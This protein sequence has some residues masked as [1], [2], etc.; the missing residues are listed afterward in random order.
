MV[1]SKYFWTWA[2]SWYYISI[3]ACKLRP[4]FIMRGYLHWCSWACS[5]W[6]EL[7][8]QCMSKGRVQYYTYENV[9]YHFWRHVADHNILGL[10]HLLTSER[11]WLNID[12]FCEHYCHIT[13]TYTVECQFNIY[14]TVPYD[15]NS[16]TERR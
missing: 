12:G 14:Q 5:V 6:Y 15:S 13:R 7:H 1:I 10:K 9:L 4:S 16:I 3:Y 2:N 8:F 11:T